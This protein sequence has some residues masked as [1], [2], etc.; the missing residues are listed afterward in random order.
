MVSV[1]SHK[2]R[3]PDCSGIVGSWFQ[4]TAHGDGTFL[5]VR[6]SVPQ[7]GCAFVSFEGGS[8]RSMRFTEDTKV[9]S[10]SRVER[11]SL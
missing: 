11:S 2:S 7:S 3:Q 5:W 9:K 6:F 4:A 1:C 8:Y 10:R